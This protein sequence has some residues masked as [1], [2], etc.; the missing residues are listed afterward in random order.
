V[1]RSSSGCDIGAY[2]TSSADLGLTAAAPSTSAVGSP[3]VDTYTV[4]NHGP[5]PASGATVIDAIPAGSVYFSSSS[6][7]GSCSGTT[8]VVCSL[9]TLD[10]ANTGSTTTATVTITVIPSKTGTLTNTAG[11]SSATADPNT[12]NNAASASTVVLSGPTVT[13]FSKP[14][15]LTG[16]A[17][18]ITKSKAKLSAIINPAGQATVYKIQYGTSKKFGKTAK[19]KTLAAS[20]TPKGV[21]ISVKGLKAGKTYHFRIVAT[22]A[23][24]TS[25]G[26]SVSFKTK[27]AKKKKKKK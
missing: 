10:S 20:T 12:A 23:S 5:G 24:G 21:V 25:D 19:G 18:Q 22:N 2:Q 15:V 16:V 6:S 11:V 3:I 27:K 13:V 8:T 17:S 4:T 14:V 7:Q 1:P 9:G 26:Q